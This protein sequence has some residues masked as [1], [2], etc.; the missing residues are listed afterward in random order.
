MRRAFA[1]L[2]ALAVALPAGA[3]AEPRTLALPTL[4]GEYALDFDDARIDEA[5]L[6]RLVALSPHLAGWQS[7][8]VAPRLELCVAGDPAYLE[9]GARTPEAP[10]FLWNA[11]VNLDSAARAVKAL[12]EARHPAELEP[13]VAWLSRSL[14]FSLWLEETRLDYYRT[15]NPAALRRR[16][17]DVDA[18]AVCRGPLA[19][20]A[21]AA[22]PAAR[23]HLAAHDWH[24]CVNDAYR[25]RLGD[26]PLD[27]WER[28]LRANGI[29]E[30]F[31]ERTQEAP[32]T[33]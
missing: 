14:A 19:A 28:F 8:A 20:L 4:F 30:R 15:W 23:H 32:V 11:R 7:Q 10:N 3:A 16:Y 33:R 31:T 26:Y 21:A 27:A 24:N 9:C 25:R 6:R 22:T 5:T 18:A 1:A 2:V 12:R 13:V 17:E 29:T